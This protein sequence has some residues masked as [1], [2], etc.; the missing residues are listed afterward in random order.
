MRAQLSRNDGGSPFRHSLAR[1]AAAAFAWGCAQLISAARQY[2]SWTLEGGPTG[3]PM[4][5]GQTV[6]VAI[7]LLAAWAIINA[8]RVDQQ[9]RRGLRRQ[10]RCRRSARIP[11]A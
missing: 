10:H 4:T 6:G 5:V 8:L 3:D 7:A 9:V 1:T 11:L 2:S